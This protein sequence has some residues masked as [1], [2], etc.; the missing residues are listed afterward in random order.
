[1]KGVIGKIG[2]L[3]YIDPKYDVSVSTAC[4]GLNAILVENQ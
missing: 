1:L 3:A 4:G 2:D